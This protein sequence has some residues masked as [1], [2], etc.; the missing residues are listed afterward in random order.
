MT[1]VHRVN[2]FPYVIKITRKI[3]RDVNCLF[4]LRDVSWIDRVLEFVQMVLA[5][6]LEVRLWMIRVILSVN[7]M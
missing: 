3:D 1:Y 7:R 6:I 2:S 5:K 4:E